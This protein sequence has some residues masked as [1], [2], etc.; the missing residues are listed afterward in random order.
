MGCLFS[1]L[2]PRRR[3]T[4]SRIDDSR[5]GHAE[6]LERSKEQPTDGGVTGCAVSFTFKDLATATQSF[7]QSNL[8]G[9]GGF[10]KVYSG[11][12]ESGQIVA[13]KRLNLE[14]LQGAK[15][16]LTEVLILS[17]L[18]HSNLVNLVG[19]CTE[20]DQRLLV[21]EF[22]PKGSL[23]D[24]LFCRPAVALLD[25]NTRIKI[26]LGSAHGLAYL[27][28]VANPPVIYR[29]MKAANVLLDDD[30]NPKLS[31][32]GLAKI[33]PVGDNTHVSTR[34]MGTYGYCAPDY[35]MSGKLTMK[36]DIYSFGVLVLELITGR[37]AFDSSKTAAEQ[38]LV[39]W[40]SPFLNDRRRFRKLADP[41]LQGCYPGKPFHQLVVIASMCLQEQPHFR[42]IIGD[43]VV[44]INYVASQ[45]YSPEAGCRIKS[46]PSSSPLCNTR[47]PSRFQN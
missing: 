40:A 44:A 28:D 19:Y 4:S 10:G 43:V 5:R 20:G 6:S 17:T 14:G 38:N 26:A 46:S 45:P 7:K 32:F 13:I 22:M 24:H 15:E 39:T 16:F 9:E 18:Q 12:L 29:D 47:T 2:H 23:E 42:P 11:R 25:W 30:F 33:G 31:D 41:S 36:S 27:H 37:K 35:A 3:E 34:V 8:L 1:C 21:Y